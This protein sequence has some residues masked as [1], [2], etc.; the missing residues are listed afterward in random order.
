MIVIVSSASSYGRWK[1]R[2]GGMVI[3]LITWTSWIS[4]I[5]RNQIITQGNS[6]IDSQALVG[7]SRIRQ[8]WISSPVAYIRIVMS[9]EESH[10]IQRGERKREIRY[11]RG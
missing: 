3:M 2:E 5:A 10:C 9:Q 4:L 8:R 1:G 6:L 11:H 7:S